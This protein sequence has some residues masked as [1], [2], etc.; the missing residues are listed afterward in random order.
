MRGLTRNVKGFTLAVEGGLGG[1]R[2]PSVPSSIP[3]LLCDVYSESI[4]FL[5]DAFHSNVSIVHTPQ[6][7]SPGDIAVVTFSVKHDVAG[8]YQDAADAIVAEWV[9][10]MAPIGVDVGLVQANCRLYP[11]P[12]PSTQVIESIDTYTGARSGNP[13][14]DIITALVHKRT[15][16]I[17]RRWRGRMFLPYTFNIADVNRQG[18]VSQSVV[19]NITIAMENFRT[20][21]G[22]L[23][24]ILFLTHSEESLGDPTE[25]IELSCATEAGYQRRRMA[26][27]D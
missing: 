23:G 16:L 18:G 17:G 10:A 6:G 2:M 12:S 19:D 24:H 14:Q 15:A 27:Y 11:G 1:R 9:Q 20:S 3:Y 4:G 13:E 5:P 21:I 26:R 25:V 7:A 8:S 22:A